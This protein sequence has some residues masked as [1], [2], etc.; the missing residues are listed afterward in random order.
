[1]GNGKITLEPPY[2]DNGNRL[3]AYVRLENGLD[4]GRELVRRCLC[5]EGYT[6][7]RKKT[8]KEPHVGVG[9]GA[10]KGT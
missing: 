2:Q 5:K 10:G 8:I 1:M 4:F 7:E 3:L 6:H 9:N